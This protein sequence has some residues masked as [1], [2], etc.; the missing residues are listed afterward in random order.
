MS[1]Q[2]L[3]ENAPKVDE[4]WINKWTRKKTVIKDVYWDDYLWVWV[5]E[6]TNYRLTALLNFV[7]VHKKLPESTPQEKRPKIIQILNVA[8]ELH[9]SEL[10]ALADDGNIYYLNK[11]WKLY[12]IGL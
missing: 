11:G 8:A 7:D 6:S 3:P 5:V 12:A 1:E 4:V 10:L 2:E 9:G